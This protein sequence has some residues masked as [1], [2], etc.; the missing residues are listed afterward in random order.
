MRDY[1]FDLT[2]INDKPATTWDKYDIP[3]KGGLEWQAKIAVAIAFEIIKNEF[4]PTDA[5]RL[6][7]LLNV[8]PKTMLSLTLR[9][10]FTRDIPCP[11]PSAYGKWQLDQCRKMKGGYD[12]ANYCPSVIPIPKEYS[13]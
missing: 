10:I 8:D 13:R 3:R 9:Y 5:G 4:H 2:D 12:G 6:H 1:P 11:I 7:R